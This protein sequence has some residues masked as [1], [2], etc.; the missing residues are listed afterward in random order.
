[1]FFCLS[2][3]SSTLRYLFLGH[4]EQSFGLWSPLVESY[5][6][7]SFI[8]DLIFPTPCNPVRTTVLLSRGWTSSFPEV[9]CS[10]SAD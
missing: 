10:L 2:F 8:G 4:S 1:M 9:S 5:R 7:L 3:D 6:G